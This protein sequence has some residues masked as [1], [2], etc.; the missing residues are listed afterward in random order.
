MSDIFFLLILSLV[1]VLLV[2][3]LLSLL[4]KFSAK[5]RQKAHRA[6]FLV[7]WW[8]I[9]KYHCDIPPGYKRFWYIMNRA[10]WILIFLSVAYTLFVGILGWN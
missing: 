6:Y 7:R 5:I 4:S 2:A 1:F 3:W 9:G 8:L 10:F